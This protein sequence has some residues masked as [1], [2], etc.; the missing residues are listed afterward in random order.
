MAA[1]ARS[2]C[3]SSV[4]SMYFVPLTFTRKPGFAPL[5]FPWS[6][7]QL[8]SAASGSSITPALQKPSNTCSGD[9]SSL[10]MRLVNQL[11]SGTSS[12]AFTLRAAPA[13]FTRSASETGLKTELSAASHAKDDS[14][15]AGAHFLGSPLSA[16]HSIV[17]GTRS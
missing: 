12:N 5:S 10:P 1:V 2:P 13:R 6:M 9:M 3:D 14:Y 16:L 8:P 15:I 11:E 17:K 4:L 7:T